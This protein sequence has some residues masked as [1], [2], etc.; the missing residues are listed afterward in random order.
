VLHPSGPQDDAPS[1]GVVR[2]L[3]RNSFLYR[4]LLG[5]WTFGSIVGARPCIAQDLPDHR[6]V[7]TST[8]LSLDRFIYDGAGETAF[9]VH[10]SS[11][12]AGQLRPELTVAL[13]PQALLIPALLIAPD[14]GVA[15]DISLPYATLLLKA[16][17]SA[18]AALGRTAQVIP[19][20]H[21][22]VGF[23]LRIDDRT[24]IRLDATRHFYISNQEVEPVWSIG[25]GLSGLRRP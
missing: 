16:G 22:G 10:R 2:K 1:A 12:C 8:G 7:G 4:A 20:G 17:G 5:L 13:F 19:G 21:L 6:L 24:G 25:I 11:L 9:S 14:V 23:V 15:Y 3:G 18:I